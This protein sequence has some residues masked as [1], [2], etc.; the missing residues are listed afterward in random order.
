MPL[1]LISMPCILEHPY[2]PQQILLYINSTEQLM[3]CH[4]QE[5]KSTPTLHRQKASPKQPISYHKPGYTGYTYWQFC[6]RDEQRTNLHAFFSWLQFWKSSQ[7]QKCKAAL[8][9]LSYSISPLETWDLSGYVMVGRSA[10]EERT[11]KTIIKLTLQPLL[12]SIYFSIL[13]ICI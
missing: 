12:E 5:Q 2:E 10:P 3:H 8:R 13:S 1:D 4:F 6:N 9:E 11:C 7:I